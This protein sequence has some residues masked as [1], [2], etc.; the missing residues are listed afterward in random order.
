LQEVLGWLEREAAEGQ[1]YAA[2]MI[3]LYHLLR[4]RTPQALLE[5]SRRCPAAPTSPQQADLAALLAAAAGALPAPQRALAVATA[6]GAAPALLPATEQDAARGAAGVR[7][8]EKVAE[9]ARAELAPAMLAVG[10]TPTEA[11]LVGSVPALLER[12][13]EASA[14]AAAREAAPT[15][16]QQAREAPVSLFGQPAA[17]AAHASEARAGAGGVFGA[18]GDDADAEAAAGVP[19]GSWAAAAGPAH[20]FDRVLGLAAPG[21]TPGGRGKRRYFGGGARR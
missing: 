4:G 5:Y 11:P 19:A 9:V 10:P 2:L 6:P 3:P 20:E 12:Q 21:G 17:G 16:A 14:A 13:R 18:A 15:Q 1:A 8:M 7:L